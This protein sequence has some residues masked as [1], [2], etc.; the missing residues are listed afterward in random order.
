MCEGAQLLTATAAASS[1]SEVDKTTDAIGRAAVTVAAADGAREA[2]GGS[3]SS[4][5][6]STTSSSNLSATTVEDFLLRGPAEMMRGLLE[7][8]VPVAVVI[9]AAAAIATTGASATDEDDGDDN[10]NDDEDA[11]LVDDLLEWVDLRRQVTSKNET[12]LTCSSKVSEHARVEYSH[13]QIKYIYTSR[14]QIEGVGSA[15]LFQR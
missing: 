11:D 6:E 1:G 3:A 14:Q 9:V 2:A 10:G 5:S 7:T 13:L 4:E 15:R 12:A 8:E